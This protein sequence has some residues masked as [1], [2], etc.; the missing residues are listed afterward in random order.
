MKYAFIASH[1]CY[2]SVKSMCKVLKVTRSGY[3]AW[4]KRPPSKREQTDQ[5]LLEWIKKVFQDSRK[6]YGSPRIYAVLRRHG[7]LCGHNRVA[8]LMHVHGIV[9][10]RRHRRFPITTQ[11]QPG[12][13]PAPNLLNRDFSAD[14]PNRK[15]VTDI[16]YIDT[17]E[18]WLY[19]ASVMDL[20]SR[21]VVGWA[22]SDK[23]DSS[24][25]TNALRMAWT[26]RR[27]LRGLLH[28]SD[29]G[30]QFAGAAYQQVLADIGCQ[31]SMN[32]TGECYDNAT[33]ESFFA[34]LKTECATGQFATRAEARTTIFDYLEGWYNRQR[35]HSSLDYHSP[36]EF[37]ALSG[38]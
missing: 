10:R 31:V 16:T 27:P 26:T 1:E 4:C 3:Y 19:L 23:I 37:E 30:S 25:A 9:A 6:T 5:M 7:W 28:H 36:A 8:R 34:T 17:A 11:R 18:G 29:Q 13:V 12:A 2:F 35:L 24:L 20:F 33:M 15:W 21:K 32:R 38:H 14:R 22:M